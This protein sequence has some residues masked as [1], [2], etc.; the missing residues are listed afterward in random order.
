MI[1]I[2]KD[3]VGVTKAGVLAGGRSN[4]E[5]LASGMSTCPKDP[6]AERLHL[7]NNQNIPLGGNLGW[8]HNGRG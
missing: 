7:K 5:N 8:H 1:R 6:V 2:Y 3:I 4:V